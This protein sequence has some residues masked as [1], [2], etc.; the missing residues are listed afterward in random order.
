MVT[1]L[2][3][4]LKVGQMLNPGS[5]QDIQQHHVDSQIHFRKRDQ[6]LSQHSK[7]Q[8]W[9]PRDSAMPSSPGITFIE[10]PSFIKHGLAIYIFLICFAKLHSQNFVYKPHV[11]SNH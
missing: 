2:S 6:L 1:K 8:G 4:L 3:I 9:P 7:P 10:N 5:L 11:S